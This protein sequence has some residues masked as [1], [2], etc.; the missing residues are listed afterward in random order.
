MFLIVSVVWLLLADL[1]GFGCFACDC[2]VYLVW[3]SF[4]WLVRVGVSGC[5]VCFDVC[6]GLIFGWWFWLMF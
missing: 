1:V 5:F 6:C 3:I 2:L 4:V